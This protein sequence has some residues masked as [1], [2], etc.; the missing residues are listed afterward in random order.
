MDDLSIY[1]NILTEMRDH[2]NKSFCIT[3]KTLLI[4]ALM[5]GGGATLSKFGFDFIV[6]KTELISEDFMKRL[7][8]WFI[9]FIGFIFLFNMITLFTMRQIAEDEKIRE[10]IPSKEAGYDDYEDGEALVKNPAV[11]HC[12]NE[13]E[14]TM[15]KP[16]NR[17]LANFI[18]IFCITGAMML[19]DSDVG[20]QAAKK[21]KLES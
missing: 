7:G 5:F 20:I 12:V 15:M 16:T 17:M 2:D 19:M 1:K 3:R 14:Y 11:I 6:N 13:A 4:G 8:F 18:G 9:I 21:A 10:F